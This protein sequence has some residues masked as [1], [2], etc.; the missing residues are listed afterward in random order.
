M[1][2]LRT[3]RTFNET[4]RELEAVTAAAEQDPP[5]PSSK[6]HHVNCSLSSSAGAPI[7]P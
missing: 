5:E 1:S 4:Y 7:G 3:H 6:R 2:K